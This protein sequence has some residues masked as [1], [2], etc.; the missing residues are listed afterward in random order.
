MR[1]LLMCAGI[2]AYFISFSSIAAG[3]TS[4]G[5]I[6]IGM[7]KEEYLSE[8][9]VTSPTDC[10]IL[11][12]KNGK[13]VHF[14]L[15]NISAHVISFMSPCHPYYILYNKTKLKDPRKIIFPE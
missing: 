11:K 15:K 12:D 4:V 5:N 7:S 1:N 14:E 13:P 8:I 9:G 6:K 2:F 3:P 10:K